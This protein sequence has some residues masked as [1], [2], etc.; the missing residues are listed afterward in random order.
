[1]PNAPAETLTC[2]KRKM[3]RVVHTC[4]LRT[5]IRRLQSLEDQDA[6][7]GWG[8]SSWITTVRDKLDRLGP[9][10]RHNQYPRTTH[11]I[12]RFFRAFQRFYKTRGG[13][14]SVLSAQRELML[15]V[16]VY[17]F[18]RQVESGQAPI[19]QI[20]P[21]AKDMPFYKIINAPF[22]YGLAN[23]C[24]LEMRDERNLATA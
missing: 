19:E 13:F 4:D 9:A 20:V 14:H 17:V 21:H 11:Q 7:E 8:L 12:E 10:L 16:V 22:R 24:A 3:K 1:M 2:L 5:V 15:F 18:T 23:I 6:R